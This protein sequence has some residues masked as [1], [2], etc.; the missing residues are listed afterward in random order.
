M[1]VLTQ[2]SLEFTPSAYGALLISSQKAFDVNRVALVDETG[3]QLFVKAISQYQRNKLA[4]SFDS[5][6]LGDLYIRKIELY[7]DE[8]LLGTVTTRVNGVDFNIYTIKQ[9]YIYVAGMVIDFIDAKNTLTINY[10][11]GSMTNGI[12][13]QSQSYLSIV[14]SLLDMVSAGQAQDLISTDPH[15]DLKLGSDDKLLVQTQDTDYLAYYLLAK[16]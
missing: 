6:F 9:G 4:V 3:Y 10:Y 1:S 8:I 14:D 13:S 15:N 7:Q 11:K 12:S 5:G 2:N 16:G